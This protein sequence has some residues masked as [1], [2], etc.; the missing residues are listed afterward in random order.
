MWRIVVLVLLVLANPALGGPWPREKGKAF[1]AMGVLDSGAGSFYGEYGLGGDWTIGADGFGAYDYTGHA[2]VFASR[3]FELSA[4][5]MA[6]ELGVQMQSGGLIP[7]DPYGLSYGLDISP[8]ELRIGASWGR[9]LS[10]MQGG[11]L[12][13]GASR[14]LGSVPL[15][16]L[17]ITVGV[18]PRDWCKVYAQL[19]GSHSW[20]ATVWRVEGVAGAKI[21]DT[22][23]LLLSYSVGI[24]GDAPKVGLVIWQNF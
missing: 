1:T 20:Q 6:L 16:K 8:P 2:A 7:L 11:W 22:Q 5:R 10:V 13:V 9:G 24:S 23:D 18:S 12:T 21:S 15:T 19:Q 3:S 14:G 17:E 4:S